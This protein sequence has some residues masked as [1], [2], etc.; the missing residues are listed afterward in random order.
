M[1]QIDSAK[2]A[3]VGET[4]GYACAPQKTGGTRCERTRNINQTR[5]ELM[6]IVDSL[7]QAFASACGVELYPPDPGTALTTLDWMEQ[8]AMGVC[9]AQSWGGYYIMLGFH[10]LGLA[11]IV[12]ALMVVD[13]RVLGVARGISVQ[14]L[15]KF[16]TLGWWGFWINFTS[17]VALLFSEA[18]KMF[19]DNTFRWKLAL[20]IVGMITTTLFSKSILKPAAQDNAAILDTGSAKLQA[21][22]S[23]AIW[24]AVIIVGRMIAYLAQSPA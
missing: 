13:L 10:S 24:I 7:S 2:N 1:L 3:A 23:F 19:Y 12:G 14:A 17:G 18:N 22:F 8:S 21:V 9:I 4:S 15:P 16:V 11:M 6:S 20:I 5:S